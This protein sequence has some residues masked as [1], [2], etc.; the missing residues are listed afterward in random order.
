MK[1]QNVFEENFDLSGKSS[2]LQK[3]FTFVKNQKSF[4]KRFCLSN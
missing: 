2:F 4:E 3:I 1:N